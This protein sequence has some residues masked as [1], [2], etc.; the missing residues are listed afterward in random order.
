MGVDS[1][2]GF[3]GEVSV[4]QSNQVIEYMVRHVHSEQREMI[5]FPRQSPD[6]Q[7]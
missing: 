5:F 1:P 2:P 6:G 7:I 4:K 3:H